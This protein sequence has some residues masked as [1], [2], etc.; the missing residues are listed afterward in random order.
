M[1]SIV[2]IVYDLCFI[3]CVYD[4]AKVL[5]DILNIVHASILIY[6]NNDK[7]NIA[8]IYFNNILYYLL[9]CPLVSLHC[10]DNKC[11]YVGKILDTFINRQT[12]YLVH[13]PQSDLEKATSGP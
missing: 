10:F 2:K 5:L 3:I 9:L 4:V 1:R 7:I 8:N 12:N 11:L 6:A 13:C